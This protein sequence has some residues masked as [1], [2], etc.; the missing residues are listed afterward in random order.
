MKA[1][2]AGM[3][4][5]HEVVLRPS[6]LSNAE[7]HVSK[8]DL[9]WGN[10]HT[11]ML[12]GEFETQNGLCMGCVGK[13]R[14]GCADLWVASF[15]LWGQNR[16]FPAVSGGEIRTADAVGVQLQRQHVELPAT[17]RETGWW[18]SVVEESQMRRE[19]WAGPESHVLSPTVSGPC[20]L[21]PSLGRKSEFM[22]PLA[23]NVW[24]KVDVG[25]WL[26]M[27]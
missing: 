16:S 22:C 15:F 24:L 21:P 18:K 3:K 7:R 8:D 4:D 12:D 13:P 1:S 9:M 6:G 14:C 5:R 27:G 25:K 17:G 20:V 10:A 11:V 19:G 2:T 23:S 26:R